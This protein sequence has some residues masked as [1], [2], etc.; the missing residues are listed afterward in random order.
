MVPQCQFSYKALT[1]YQFGRV[2]K[3]YVKI[4]ITFV[5]SEV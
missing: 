1:D 2:G 4:Y 3:G 5:N